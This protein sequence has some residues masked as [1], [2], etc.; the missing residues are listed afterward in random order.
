MDRSGPDLMRTVE[1]EVPFV[2]DEIH[3]VIKFV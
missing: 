1:K 2:L 3:K